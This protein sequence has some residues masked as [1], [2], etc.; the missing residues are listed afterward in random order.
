MVYTFNPNPQEIEAGDSLCF[1]DY[2]GL[3]SKFQTSRGY[4][5]RSEVWQLK[6]IS[7]KLSLTDAYLIIL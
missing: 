2:P 5:V 7:L 1:P 3:H 6:F 4:V